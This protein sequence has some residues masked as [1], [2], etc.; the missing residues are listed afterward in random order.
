MNSLWKTILDGLTYQ[1][2]AGKRQPRIYTV[3]TGLILLLLFAAGGMAGLNRYLLMSRVQATPVSVSM[4]TQVIESSET[5]PPATVQSEGNVSSG[6]PT[7]STEWSFSPTLISEN[8]QVI[9]PACVYQGLERTIAWA[10]AVREGYSR[11]EAT[12]QLGFSE[13]P[14]RQLEMVTIPSDADELVDVPVSFIPPNPDFTEWRLNARGEPAVTYALRGCFRTSTITGNRVEIWGGDYPVVCIVVEDAE[15]THIVYSLNGHTYTSPATPM[16]SFLLFGYI[17]DGYWVWLGTQTE[18]KI[19][20]TDPQEN[21]SDRLTVATLYD[22]QPWDA[23]WL[24]NFHHLPMR[25]LPKNWQ[26]LTDENEKQF[27]LSALSANHEGGT[28]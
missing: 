20:I 27:I 21:A 15:N 16:R 23:K 19:E 13:M 28:P 14:M 2:L 8:H 3:I 10:L 24:M 4:T 7:D 12:Q 18:P 25:P 17:S 9:Q 22:S 6:C 5:E 26:S 1:D 11:A